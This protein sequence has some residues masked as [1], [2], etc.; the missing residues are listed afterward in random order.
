MCLHRFYQSRGGAAS[1]FVYLLLN[2]SLIGLSSFFPLSHQIF[3]FY[4]GL[5]LNQFG[6]GGKDP[7]FSLSEIRS[8][9]ICWTKGIKKLF[10]ISASH[11][12]FWKHHSAARSSSV[13]NSAVS[14][15]REKQLRLWLEHAQA[16]ASLG[17][18]GRRSWAESGIESAA[19]KG[20]GWWQWE[21]RQSCSS[22]APGCLRQAWAQES[23][24]NWALAWKCRQENKWHG[25]DGFWFV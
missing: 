16:R 7:T 23:C 9:S 6:L 21:V 25:Q 14:G 19:T 2:A 24:G 10:F 12:G 11:L 20:G 15:R 17:L 18:Q 4:N 3:D 22:T 5:S 1:N 8:F 13:T